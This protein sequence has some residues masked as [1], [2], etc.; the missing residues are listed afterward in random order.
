MFRKMFVADLKDRALDW[1]VAFS[2]GYTFSD[3]GGGFPIVH[4]PD[5]DKLL[6]PHFNSSGHQYGYHPTGDYTQGMFI[7]DRED[8]SMRRYFNPESA[9][10]GT[11]YAKVCRES[12]AN[13][14][15]GKRNS[16]RGPDLL[17]AAMRCYVTR[18]AGP[19]IMIPVGLL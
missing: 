19:E 3:G 8:I 10:H 17:T 5:G 13:I 18:M 9:A 4:T 15:W 2:E 14:T 6:G 16:S 11:C 12:G 7:V 1:A